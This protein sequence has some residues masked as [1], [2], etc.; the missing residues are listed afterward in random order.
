MPKLSHS[1]GVVVFVIFFFL[2]L[3]ILILFALSSFYLIMNVKLEWDR[4]MYD[5]K[6]VKV[7]TLKVMEIREVKKIF[8]NTSQLFSTLLQFL[9]FILF[10]FSLSKNNAKVHIKLRDR[11]N[12][13]QQKKVE[14][15]RARMAC[16]SSTGEK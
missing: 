10:S 6:K 12:K 5:G 14:K 15:L 8:G 13:L 4:D 9:F 1:T 3:F 11:N 16:A 7:Y 2:L